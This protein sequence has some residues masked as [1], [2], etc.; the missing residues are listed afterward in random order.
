[1]KYESHDYIMN[2]LTFKTIME[3]MRDASCMMQI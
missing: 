2:V 3:R 1:M